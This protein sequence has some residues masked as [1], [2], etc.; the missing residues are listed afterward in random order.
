MI[1]RV[2]QCLTTL[3]RHPPVAK[4]SCRSSSICV[5]LSPALASA[6]ILHRLLRPISPLRSS[7]LLFPLPSCPT[8]LLRP[9][10][11]ASPPLDHRHRLFSS[12]PFL[13][14]SPRPCRLSLAQGIVRSRI[15][16]TS[17]RVLLLPCSTYLPLRLGSPLSCLPFPRTH[18][19]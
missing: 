14:L 15:P 1:I 11:M 18:L 16:E 5:P 3:P 12:H 9:L 19:L 6:H 17:N 13:S 4:A 7:L 8:V 10:T 2:A